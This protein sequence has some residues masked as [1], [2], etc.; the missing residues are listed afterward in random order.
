MDGH[1]PTATQTSVLLPWASREHVLDKHC[2]LFLDYVLMPPSAFAFS[3][4]I[5][6]AP[7]FPQV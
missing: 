6:Y 2:I 4:M 3:H 7:L 5:S 1:I